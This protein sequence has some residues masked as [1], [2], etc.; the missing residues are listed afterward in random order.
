M[1]TLTVA[2]GMHPALAAGMT[3]SPAPSP[4]P[5]ATHQAS[6]SPRDAAVE[7]AGPERLKA[8]VRIVATTN[9][10]AAAVTEKKSSH[11][12]FKCRGWDG[13]YLELYQES[14]LGDPFASLR[15]QFLGS[16]QVLHL[17]QVKMTARVGGRMAVDGAAFG[18]SGNLQDFDGGV[19]LRRLRV[20]V[21]GDCILLLPVS[22]QIELGY[23]PN[24]FDIEES[25]LTF[26]NLGYFG[27]LKIG[28]YRTPFS[29]ENY[30]STRDIRFM[31]PAAPVT[32]LAPGVNAGMRFARSVFN[33]RMT[34]TLG[35]FGSGSSSDFGD[36]SRDYGRAVLRLTGLPIARQ[37]PDDPSAQRLL[38]LGLNF[39]WLYSASSSVRYRTRPE[40]HLAPYVLDTGE[41]D[42]NNACTL[43]GEAAWI[44]G[45]LSVQGE[46]LASQV[47]DAQ[48][49]RPIFY[50][51]YTQVGWFLTGE[52]RPYNRRE[53]RFTRIVPRQ[54]FAWQG[55]GWGAW[56]VV[57]RFSFTDLNSEDISGGRMGLVTAGVNWHPTAH[58]H[59]ALNFI[60]GKADGPDGTGWMNIFETRVEVDF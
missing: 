26:R 35:F 8:Q 18:T 11:W 24:E 44:N 36:A 7:D 10:P 52:S 60:T 28:Q 46:F 2:L 57:G 5:A 49:T 27:T 56:E 33:E 37:T 41:I 1:V 38:H 13:L 47:N 53:G 23:I 32:A 39:N 9:A 51:F 55:G 4:P 3:D 21:R 59:W 42:A 58:V 43:D 19:Q 45:P 54:D 16:N 25:Y 20:I 29:L 30:T 12:E 22:Y 6:A 48:H 15:R 14:P 50:G 31:E 34:W 40:S 17:E